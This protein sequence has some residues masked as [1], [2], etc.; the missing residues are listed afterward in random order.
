MSSVGDATSTTPVGTSIFSLPSTLSS[1]STSGASND[2]SKDDFMKLMLAQ[3]QNQD[4]MQPEDNSQF[5][6]QTAQFNELEQMQDL[7]KTISAMADAQQLGQASSL[8]GKAVSATDDNDKS[9]T[10]AVTGVTLE[11]GVAKLHL[12]S[13]TV[14]DLDKVVAVASDAK[15]LPTITPATGTTPTTPTYVIPT[16]NGSSTSSGSGSVDLSA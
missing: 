15:S 3:L 11:S 10:G 13:N 16:N 8:I 9:V 1:S 5:L 14:V 7:N 4:P 2:P 6:A 12:D